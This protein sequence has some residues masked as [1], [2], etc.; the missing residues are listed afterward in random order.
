MTNEEAI[1]DL[2]PM[3]ELQILPVFPG[4]EEKVVNGVKQLVPCCSD[5]KGKAYQYK[6]YKVPVVI[7]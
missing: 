4:Y 6:L 3:D 7:N 5:T 1:R 2:D